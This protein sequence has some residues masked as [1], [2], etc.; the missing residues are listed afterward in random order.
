MVL[1][2]WAARF[3][4]LYLVNTRVD[5]SNRILLIREVVELIK[6]RI[7]KSVTELEV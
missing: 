6:S 2:V 3:V 4:A 1:A 7:K 5:Q